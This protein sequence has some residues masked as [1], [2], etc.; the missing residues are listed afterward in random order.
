MHDDL[1]MSYGSD[2]PHWYDIIAPEE[3]ER[4]TILSSDQC[5]IDGENFFIRGCLELPI[6][7]TGDVFVWGVWVSLS[8]KNFERADEVWYRPERINEPPYFGWFSTKIPVYPDTLN[9]KTWVHT[10][11]LGQRPLIELEE[12]DHPLSIEQRKGITL[13]RV[14]EF[15]ELLLHHYED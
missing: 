2:A 10:L 7:D 8:Q 6:L 11:G 5:V 9:L 4:R 1:P 15:A 3:R 12:T 14:R 13:D